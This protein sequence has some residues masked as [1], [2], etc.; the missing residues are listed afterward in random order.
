M[1]SI[2][3]NDYLVGYPAGYS[4]FGKP[5]HKLCLLIKNRLIL[6]GE[7]VSRKSGKLTKHEVKWTGTLWDWSENYFASIQDL[8]VEEVEK[9]LDEM[10]KLWELGDK[11][12]TTEPFDDEF[13]Y[14][15]CLLEHANGETDEIYVGY[16]L[17][18]IYARIT[19]GSKPEAVK[20]D[21]GLLGGSQAKAFNRH[22][23]ALAKVYYPFERGITSTRNNQPRSKNSCLKAMEQL[24]VQS[25]LV[26][27]KS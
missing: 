3:E 8:S 15:V 5:L 22:K 12:P 4:N 25:L 10:I 6:R 14:E 16:C 27:K 26:K 23:K 18:I 2:V 1:A 24:K 19:T 13:Q 17:A 11:A 20:T 7:H 9:D 21:T